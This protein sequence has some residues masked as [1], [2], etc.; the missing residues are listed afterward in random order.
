[1]GRDWNDRGFEEFFRCAL[2]MATRVAQ[3]ITGDAALAQDAAGEALTRALYRWPQVSA[4]ENPGGWVVRVAVNVALDSLPRRLPTVALADEADGSEA[5][6]LR[7]ALIAALRA[8]PLRQREVIVLRYVAGL[9][10][11]EVAASL[12]ISENSVRTHR[13]RAL[14]H[15]RTALGTDFSGGLVG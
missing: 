8:L 7:I 14:R 13:S 3:R 2:P 1:M 12:G 11:D 15:M 5:V 10:E 4:M 9:S 6:I